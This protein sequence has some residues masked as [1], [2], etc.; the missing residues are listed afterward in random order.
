MAQDR[1]FQNKRV[2]E[3]RI[4]DLDGDA[5]VQRKDRAP[6][7]YTRAS[8]KQRSLNKIAGSTGTARNATIYDTRIR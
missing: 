2:D 6:S 5:D 3:V 1:I 4:V 8:P 7:N